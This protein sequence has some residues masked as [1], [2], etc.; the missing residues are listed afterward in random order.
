MATVLLLAIAVLIFSII[1]TLLFIGLKV[2]EMNNRFKSAESE[3]SEINTS[4]S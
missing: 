3:M 2:K 1:S 4:N